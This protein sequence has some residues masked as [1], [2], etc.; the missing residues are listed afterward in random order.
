[1]KNVY[2]LLD[3]KLFHHFRRIKFYIHKSFLLPKTRPTNFIIFCISLFGSYGSKHSSLLVFQLVCVWVC[4]FWVVYVVVYK[5][6]NNDSNCGVTLTGEGG[7]RQPPH[8][9]FDVWWRDYCYFAVRLG[10]D[11]KNST[12]IYCSWWGGW[13]VGV[14]SLMMLMVK[15]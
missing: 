2:L 1:M 14:L 15:V 8:H 11:T 12:S 5:W 9:F 7:T 6:H 13:W 4:V 10:I 3:S